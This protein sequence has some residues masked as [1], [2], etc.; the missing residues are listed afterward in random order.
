MPNVSIIIPAYRSSSALRNNLPYLMSFIKEKNLDAEVLIVDDGSADDG[1]TEQVAKSNSCTYLSY[2]INLGKGGAVRY[3]MQ[4]AS[5]DFCIF[6]D[7]DIPFEKDAFERFL[8]YLDF[9][10]FDV[11]I[12]DRTLPGS[13]YFAEVSGLRKFGSNIFS[14]IV[15]RFVAGGHFDTQCGMKGFRGEVARDLFS[16][17]RIKGFAFDVELLYISLK[18]NYDIKRLPVVLRCQ[19]GSTVSVVR[20]GLGMVMDLFRIKWNHVNGRYKKH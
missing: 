4:H 7:V 20:H 9:K 13:S 18:R 10:E 11:V 3:G 6:T 14:F 16:V 12:G 15:G 19:E 8:Y 17:G 2:P 5:G 1:A